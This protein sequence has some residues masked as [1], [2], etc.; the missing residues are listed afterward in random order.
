MMDPIGRN[1]ADN[2]GPARGAG[3]PADAAK[4]A[5]YAPPG[6]DSVPPIMFG[7]HAPPAEHS[8]QI[9]LLTS[10]Y[11]KLRGIEST[12]FDV[13]NK[14]KAILANPTTIDREEIRKLE[15]KLLEVWREIQ[16]NDLK[17]QPDD[18]RIPNNLSETAR[19]KLT[20]SV[21]K[22]Q[23]LVRQA[24]D[25][26]DE[27][28]AIPEGEVSLSFFKESR[29]EADLNKI[30]GVLKSGHP[31]LIEEEKSKVRKAFEYPLG[32]MTED[33]KETPQVVLE[34]ILGSKSKKRAT[35]DQ[36]ADLVYVEKALVS[37][38][39]SPEE[40]AQKKCY[41]ALILLA[42]KPGY[43]YITE[44]IKEHLDSINNAGKE[45]HRR[46]EL[47]YKKEYE[48]QP[49]AIKIVLQKVQE[50]V[51]IDCE[52]PVDFTFALLR[53]CQITK[54]R[55]EPNPDNPNLDRWED[56][57]G[58]A[59]L[60][61][62]CN[63]ANLIKLKNL[64]LIRNKTFFPKDS[65]ID[66]QIGP[67][68]TNRILDTY[69]DIAKGLA[70]FGAFLIAKIGDI[71]NL[72]PV[73]DAIAFAIPGQSSIIGTS[74]REQY[75]RSLK[76][77][78]GAKAI[79]DAVFLKEGYRPTRSGDAATRLISSGYREFANYGL[80]IKNT[81]EI[82]PGELFQLT[83]KG[84]LA[85]KRKDGSYQLQQKTATLDC[86]ELGPIA[87]IEQRAKFMSFINAYATQNKFQETC[88]GVIATKD[89]SKI[90]A[91]FKEIYP[92]VT[93]PE[94]LMDL[95]R[96]AV[97]IADKF[98][99]E[100]EVNLSLAYMEAP[101]KPPEPMAPMQ[102]VIQ[103]LGE[104]LGM[105]LS[106]LPASGEIAKTVSGQSKIAPLQP[107]R[108]TAPPSTTA[109]IVAWFSFVW[110][111]LSSPKGVVEKYLKILEASAKKG[112]LPTTQQ[113]ND[114][115]T[116]LNRQ[117]EVVVLISAFRGAPRQDDSIIQ[118][119][120]KALEEGFAMLQAHPLD[121]T[122]PFYEDSKEFE[123][124][125]YKEIEEILGIEDENL[126][127][128]ALFNASSDK[129]R[130]EFIQFHAGISPPLHAEIS[131]PP[132]IKLQQKY[133]EWLQVREDLKADENL[134]LKKITNLKLFDDMKAP[135]DKT[136]YK[137]LV[138]WDIRALK[139]NW[140]PPAKPID[141]PN[142]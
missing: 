50:L 73:T 56:F 12:V 54:I 57:D 106:V 122:S 133:L 38:G 68:I 23:K 39:I 100:I 8:V 59:K 99:K 33:R 93:S 49:L 132:S 142:S 65:G 137:E 111:F 48:K 78:L 40:Q 5:A 118:K 89:F 119:N 124:E 17:K 22:L 41:D 107:G 61:E 45:I 95:F 9:E 139:Q 19:G 24:L 134:K 66:R 82:E 32:R 4:A 129:I 72:Q 67:N 29:E 96:T 43:G 120:K 69:P 87:D 75:V 110:K 103:K 14:I 46:K 125:L 112:T 83:W 121:S 58:K 138:E 51:G 31:P 84:N 97:N 21:N 2:V 94:A 42:D 28:V 86:S 52:I 13:Q 34:R 60:L 123:I 36:Y 53:L 76:T 109:A 135:F 6:A 91:V 128:Q 98:V 115:L 44:R 105:Q 117:H 64:G 71:T 62:L 80:W 30:D 114:L 37:L 47:L 10:A 15:T 136:P 16:P 35:A 102:N 90:P 25:M 11:E 85:L 81:W 131:P 55:A 101:P 74:Q 26:C 116:W 113:K 126:K 104:T 20:E 127:F 130:A 18:F 141:P 92:T 79:D 140:T 1:T 63:Q 70:P 88:K 3:S 77:A 108:I 27:A 7:S